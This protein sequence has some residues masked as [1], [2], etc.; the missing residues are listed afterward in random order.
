MSITSV[1]S[2]KEFRERAAK[3]VVLSDLNL[4]FERLKNNFVYRLRP[5][6]LNCTYLKLLKYELGVDI[7]Y[8]NVYF[9]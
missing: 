5:S 9:I 7:G 4:E 3:S 8:S 6:N 1:I 2:R